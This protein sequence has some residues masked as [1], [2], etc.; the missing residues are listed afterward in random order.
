MRFWKKGVLYSLSLSALLST[1][2]ILIQ[3]VRVMASECTA[4]CS[5]DDISVSGTYCSC[6]DYVG[7]KYYNSSTQREETKNCGSGDGEA[8]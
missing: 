4:K 1:L 7:C 5:G 2:I 3:P 8:Q 6:T